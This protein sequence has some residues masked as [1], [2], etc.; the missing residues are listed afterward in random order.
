[1]RQ[2][3][4]M[5]CGW[6]IDSMAAWAFPSFAL[7]GNWNLVLALQLPYLETTIHHAIRVCAAAD[8]I[9]FFQFSNQS[10]ILSPN[11]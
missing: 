1:M 10:S 8:D 9:H 7:G 2:A 3:I 11:L 6:A 4:A 5:M